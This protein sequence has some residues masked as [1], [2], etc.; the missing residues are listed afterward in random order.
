M[1]NDVRVGQWDRLTNVF[2]F[3]LLVEQ[4][5]YVKNNNLKKSWTLEMVYWHFH[6][7]ENSL[8]NQQYDVLIYKKI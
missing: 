6:Y 7:S 8:S 1:N 3:G 2:N 4:N 5:K